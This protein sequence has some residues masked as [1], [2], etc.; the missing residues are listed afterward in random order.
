MMLEHFDDAISLSKN[1]K[2]NWELMVHIADVSHFVP[3]G[4]LLD[5]EAKQRHQRLPTRPCHPDATGI[6]QQSLSQPAT[7]QSA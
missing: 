5:E 2:G 1:E 7:Q 4:S 3:I 6:D